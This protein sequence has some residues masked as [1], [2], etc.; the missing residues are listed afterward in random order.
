[1]P[2]QVQ[3]T[4][5]K[6][7]KKAASSFQNITVRGLKRSK[8]NKKSQYSGAYTITE[9]CGKFLRADW[10]KSMLFDCVSYLNVC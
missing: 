3:D 7:M 10:K 6:K 4:G 8:K 2:V 9:I 1:M 5:K